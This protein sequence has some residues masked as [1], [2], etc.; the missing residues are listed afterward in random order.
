M[1]SPRRGSKTFELV[2]T[3]VPAPDDVDALLAALEVDPAGA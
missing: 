3:I 1:T 2:A